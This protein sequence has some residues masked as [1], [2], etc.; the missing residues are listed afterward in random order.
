MADGSIIIDLKLENENSLKEL[1]KANKDINKSVKETEMNLKKS[2]KEIDKQTEKVDKLSKKYRETAREAEKQ[3]KALYGKYSFLKGTAIEGDIGQMVKSDK[4]YG[5]LKKLN[6]TRNEA[7]L[8]LTEEKKIL[9]QQKQTH[10]ILADKYEARKAK[11]QEINDLLQ[12]EKNKQEKIK[13]NTQNIEKNTKKI[14]THSA[15]FGKGLL[16]SFKSL[17]KISLMLVG[18][19][20]IFF[21][22][23]GSVNTWLNSSS[24][25]AKQLS[26]DIKFL[27]YTIADMLSPAIEYVVSLFYKLLG[28]VNAVVKSFTGVDY[29]A[30]AL[31][32]YTKDSKKNMQGTLA[33]F[34]QLEVYGEKEKTPSDFTGQTQEFDDLAEKMKSFFLDLTTGMDLTPLIN[35]FEKLKEALGNLGR[36]SWDILKDGYEHFLKPVGTLV[37]NKLL[38]DT[39]NFMADVINWLADTLKKIEPYW[40][41][42]LDN[43]LTP[44]ATW[45]INDFVPAF[46]ELLKSVLE[47]LTPVIE[48]FCEVF[49]DMWE[50]FF[51]PIVKFTGGIII[52]FL[53][54][55]TALLKKLGD[56]ASE[57]TY[58]LATFIELFLGFLAG[59][60]VYN[61][62][63]MV[64]PFI[65]SFISV[66][67]G[68]WGAL[69]KGELLRTISD[70]LTTFIAKINLAKIA[71]NLAAGAFGALAV[72]IGLIAINW[73]KMN[74][75]ERVIS[76]LGAVT[77][78]VTALYVAVVGL[79]SAW[80][81]GVAAA[82]IV[83]GITAV[84]GSISSAKKRAEAEAEASVAKASSIPK[85]ARGGIV[86]RPT[87]AIIGEAGRE[88][89]IPLE[90]NTEWIDELA[91]K[92]GKKSDVKITF[93]GSLAQLGRV[94]N[95]VITQDNKRIGTRRI[96]GG[97]SV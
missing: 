51:E 1:E 69:K 13:K 46:F 75:W 53:E 35:N 42:F 91:D 47:V 96:T 44:L 78:A 74:G 11:Q 30:K 87:Q 34:D 14:K 8:Q 10:I 4:S 2:Q 59:I 56:W 64:V 40:V 25:K 19:R 76:V 22:I 3:R 45:A 54:L 33:S 73:D 84:M 38:P 95:P 16:G 28:L 93:N 36:A 37:I 67:G 48:I 29:L 63:K 82:A 92:I 15:G 18:I 89:V 85:L 66:L 72:A 20:S 83:A 90:N 77:I 17:L 50:I 32:K 7:L 39:L 31:A 9:E 70:L 5:D 68:L 65:T 71:T 41:W 24:E 6:A 21:A 58:T 26:A 27:K 49:K 43:V 97:V 23:T 61:S 81:L 52:K 57:N 88:A 62:S 80:S 94:L 79:Q 55:F 86:N 60:W 12:E